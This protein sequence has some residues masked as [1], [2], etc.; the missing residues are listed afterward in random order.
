MCRVQTTHPTSDT[1]HAHAAPQGVGIGELF[2]DYGEAYIQKYQPCLQHTKLIR[3]IRVCRTPALGGIVITCKA[4][5]NKHYVYKSCGHSHCMLCQS[6]KREQWMDKLNQRLLKVPYIHTTFTIPHQLNGLFR[7]NAKQLYGL[8]MRSCW[9]TI[10]TLMSKE[11]LLPGMTAVLHTF[12]SD[13]KYHIHVHSLI[14]YGG[15]DEAGAWQYPKTKNKLASFR[16]MCATF[17]KHILKGIGRLSEK[18]QLKYHLSIE[19]LLNDVSKTRWVVHSTRPTMDTKVIQSYLARYINRTAISPSRLTYLPKQQQVHILYNDYK[20]Q[21]AGQA[22]PKEIKILHPLE[23]IHQIL[24][25]VLPP[26][27]N[28]TRHFGLHQY[29]TKKRSTISDSLKNNEATVRTV[30]EILRHLMGL[31]M[32]ICPECGSITFETEE[33][34][35]D[36]SFLLPFLHNKTPPSPSPEH[37]D[38]KHATP[39]SPIAKNKPKS[40]IF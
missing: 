35:P 25:H 28:K 27:F 38:M 7:V 1:E 8:L 34:K 14:T 6:V 3:A 12:G 16:T 36:A 17:K 15:V 21:Q 37:I 31:E 20:N 4:C 24:Q 19:E 5:G 23:A 39:E 18:N 29:C 13:M 2:R 40:L 9:K 10:K 22:A 26:Y 33:I 30:F 11:G 32:P